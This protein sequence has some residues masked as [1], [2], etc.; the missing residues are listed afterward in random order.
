M[1]KTWGNLIL[2]SIL[3][4]LTILLAVQAQQPDRDELAFQAAQARWP[5]QGFVLKI[6]LPATDYWTYE[7]GRVEIFG[8]RLII[9]RGGSW[10]AAFAMAD[11][12]IAHPY[13][14]PLPGVMPGGGQ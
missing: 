6:R 8:R 13:T 2:I 7:V 10:E 3:L 12:S 14:P 9:G 5:F 1:K 11:E 4:M